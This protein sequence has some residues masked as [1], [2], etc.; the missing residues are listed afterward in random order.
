MTTN[1]LGTV[2]VNNSRITSPNYPQHYGNNEDCY[3]FLWSK[4]QDI[5]LVFEYFHTEKNYDFVRLYNEES[6][7]IGSYH[8]KLSSNTAID[9]S[10]NRINITFTSDH[11]DIYPGFS[12]IYQLGRYHIILLT[13][14]FNFDLTFDLKL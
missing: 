10:S 6:T 9:V 1:C 12:L 13:I 3:W 8:G 2:D 7:L 4:E 11:I 14:S 5:H